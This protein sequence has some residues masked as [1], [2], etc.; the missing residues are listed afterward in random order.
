[1][2]LGE[3]SVTVFQVV[4]LS[5]GLGSAKLNTLLLAIVDICCIIVGSC[6]LM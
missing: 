3:L 5:D 2:G 6:K 1:M 4:A